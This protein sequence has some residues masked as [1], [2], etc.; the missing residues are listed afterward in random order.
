[1]IDPFRKADEI[2]R[3]GR[4]SEIREHHVQP[5]AKAAPA[6]GRVDTFAS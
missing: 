1:V 5:T 3:A 2:C 6:P 4:E